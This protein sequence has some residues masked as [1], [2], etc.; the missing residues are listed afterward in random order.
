MT[1]AQRKGDMKTMDATGTLIL[2]GDT[3]CCR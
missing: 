3:V 2:N 1:V